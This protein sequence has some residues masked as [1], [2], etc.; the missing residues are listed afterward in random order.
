MTDE[1]DREGRDQ[2]LDSYL[3]GSSRLSARYRAASRETPAPELD[4]AVLEHARAAVRTPTATPQPRRSWQQ[5]WAVPVGIAATLLV[6]I[7]LAWRVADQSQAEQTLAE[8]AAQV[9]SSKTEQRV[10]AAAAMPEPQERKD[11][12]ASSAFADSAPADQEVAEPALAEPA[13]QAYEPDRQLPDRGTAPAQDE[14]DADASGAGARTESAL[15]VAP[16]TAMDAAPAADT[17]AAAEASQAEDAE[18]VAAERALNVARAR[19]AERRDSAAKMQM[20]AAP[21]AAP[22]PPIPRRSA[23]SAKATAEDVAALL[24]VRDFDTLR[25]RYAAAALT[26]QALEGAADILDGSLNLRLIEDADG[27]WRADYLDADQ[28]M[29]CALRLRPAEDGWLLV[30]LATRP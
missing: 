13:R 9:A 17:Y 26:R 19:A 5:R 12:G 2:E 20:M 21:P 24:R 11:A 25:S 29:R 30:G 1:A 28:Q 22:E 6:G 27:S 15:R 18:V 14:A 3:A 4:R 16:D 23:V 10:P 8:S 7:D